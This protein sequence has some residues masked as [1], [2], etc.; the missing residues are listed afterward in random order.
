MDIIIYRLN[1]GVL[2]HILEHIHPEP[3]SSWSSPA[4]S[5][6]PALPMRAWLLCWGSE[7]WCIVEWGDT[8]APLCLQ[9]WDQMHWTYFICF[10]FAKGTA[11]YTVIWKDQMLSAS[12]N[13]ILIPW[14]L[15]VH[16]SL[17]FPIGVLQKPTHLFKAE[18]AC[19]ALS[20]RVQFH[21]IQ[22]NL[23]NHINGTIFYLYQPS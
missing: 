7:V 11:N 22:V 21:Q 12:L 6:H 1:T 16:S 23:S 2:G 5:L 19:L 10:Y 20:E 4:L 13:E 8:T 17:I 3:A 18:K 15:P 9:W 14:N